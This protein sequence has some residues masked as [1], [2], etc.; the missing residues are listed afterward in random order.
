MGT[1]QRLAKV[2]AEDPGLREQ[3]QWFADHGDA[4]T[5]FETSI[6]LLSSSISGDTAEVTFNE[7]TMMKRAPLADGT[8]LPDYGYGALQTATLVHDGGEWKV[9]EM[10]HDAKEGTTTMYSP[11]LLSSIRS[12]EMDASYRRWEAELEASPARP[13]ATRVA[14]ADTI[15][16]LAYVAKYWS[17]YNRAYETQ[18]NDCT[19]FVSQAL[20][21]GG[22]QE[23]AYGDKNDLSRWYYK[24]SQALPAL[25]PWTKT[26]V[27]AQALASFGTS[28]GRTK[29][30]S[31]AHM[32]AG[33]VAFF[34]WDSSRNTT[35][36]H[37]GIVTKVVGY[38]PY[39]AYHTSNR[40]NISWT[41]VRANAVAS[42]ATK[43]DFT[44]SLF[45]FHV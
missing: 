20:R 24:G 32:L 42:G 17:S 21:A 43:Y 22:R 1:P 33:D 31:S 8:S 40:Y 11:S 4:F 30:E 28:S 19:N 34:I 7:T 12:G 27:N 29:L 23:T 5:S 10:S 14:K 38:E 26:W 37:A 44:V 39:F 25:S 18:A 41:Q 3:A 2:R 35:M 16:I 13:R 9:G 45:D 36:D 15:A 6:E